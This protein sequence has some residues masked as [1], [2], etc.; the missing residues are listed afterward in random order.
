MGG[1]INNYSDLNVNYNLSNP[2]DLFNEAGGF[3]HNQNTGIISIT[4]GNSTIQ[5]S[6]IISNCSVTIN[7]TIS[8]NQTDL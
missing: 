4:S 6:G 3:V 7:G 1:V 8:G 2:G 5:N